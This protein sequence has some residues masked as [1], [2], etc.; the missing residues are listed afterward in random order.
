MIQ[1]YRAAAKLKDSQRDRDRER[2]SEEKKERQ[3]WNNLFMSEMAEMPPA[4][5]K[6][7]CSNF[8][9]LFQRRFQLFIPQ[10]QM[11]WVRTNGRHRERV[12]EREPH[13]FIKYKSEQKGLI[14]LSVQ[15]NDENADE[16]CREKK[17][18]TTTILFE[19]TPENVSLILLSSLVNLPVHFFLP[20]GSHMNRLNP[21]IGCWT[22]IR[23]TFKLLTF[24]FVLFY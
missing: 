4:W 2:K 21:S 1:I 6:L 18:T 5:H 15:D 23:A 8:G 16:F 14:H 11:E 9:I 24:F 20:F 12:A 19:M 7:V 13:D 10:P 22:L 17:T 3:Q